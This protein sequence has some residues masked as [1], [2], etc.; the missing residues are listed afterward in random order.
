MKQSI[1][2]LQEECQKIFMEKTSNFF[3]F[4]FSS[5]FDAL[6]LTKKNRMIILYGAVKKV[7]D[8]KK[9]EAQK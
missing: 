4:L 5:R 2:Y 3:P 6:G 9:E 7:R 1:S 8:K